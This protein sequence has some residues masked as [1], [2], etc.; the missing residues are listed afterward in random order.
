MK[1]ALFTKIDALNDK[2]VKIWQDVCNIESPTASKSGVDAVGE[3]FK[4]FARE[5]GWKIDVFPEER[6][7]DVVVITMNADAT[8]EPIALSGHMDT[9]HDIGS[10]GSPAVRMDDEKIYGPGVTDCK[11]GIVAGFLAMDALRECGYKSRPIVMYLQSDEEGGGK[12]SGDRTIRRICEAAKHSLAFLNLEGGTYDT[13]TL[14]R[15]GIASFEFTVKGIEEH[16]SMCA[17]EGANAILEA[18]HKIIE[19][20]KFKDHEGLTVSCTVIKG[21]TVH[22]TIAGECKF[23]AN[24][25]FATNKQLDDFRAYAEELAKEVKV[26]GCSTSVVLPRVRPAMEHSE[27]NIALF[28]KINDAFEKCGFERVAEGYSLGGADSA[29]VSVAGIPTVD[30]FGVI[31]GKIHTVEEYAYLS[32]LAFQAKRITSVI[33]HL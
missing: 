24:A 25:R 23:I 32:S 18:A 20:E 2:Y 1:D 10:F 28:N 33:L 5:R 14:Y 30:G 11:G 3:Y 27:K 31:G 22:N 17:I 8:G 9:V 13:L 7:G 29:N 4:A 26:E 16:S 19:L 21:G 12:Y 6:A 15:K